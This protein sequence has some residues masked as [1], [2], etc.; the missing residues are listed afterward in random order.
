M[1]QGLQFVFN[2]IRYVLLVLDLL[3]IIVLDV[4]VGMYLLGHTVEYWL[5]AWIIGIKEFALANVRVV[6]MEFWG[7]Q[8]E[9][10]VLLV[11]ILVKPVNQP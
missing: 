6:V 10:L 9:I 4:S 3:N 1:M 8:Q 2:V 5:F 7:H 11:Y